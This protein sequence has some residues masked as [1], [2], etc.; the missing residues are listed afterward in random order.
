[1]IEMNGGLRHLK[2]AARMLLRL[3]V[4]LSLAAGAARAETLM[5]DD[6]VVRTLLSRVPLDSPLREASRRELAI[7]T[8][9]TTCTSSKCTTLGGGNYCSRSLTLNTATGVFSG[10]MTTN[11]CP[12]HAGAYQYG[13]VKDDLV[14][15]AAAS[16][17]T[18]TVP[19]AGYTTSPKA[20]PLRGVIGYTISGGEQIY[21]KF[22]LQGASGF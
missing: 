16:C 1:M 10:S 22:F 15:A 18:Y 4:S 6:Y 8:A 13:G 5:S 19:S 2:P 17:V 20:A 7:T 12:N 11:Q 9:A 14:G 3:S 21:G